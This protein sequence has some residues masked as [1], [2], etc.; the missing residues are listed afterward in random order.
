MEWLKVGCSRN[1]HKCWRLGNNAGQIHLVLLPP[2]HG[3]EKDL[4]DVYF[5]LIFSWN[6]SKCVWLDMDA[7]K[8]KDSLSFIPTFKERHQ[9][10][11]EAHVSGSPGA[12]LCGLWA[13]SSQGTCFLLFSFCGVSAKTGVNEGHT[14]SGF[15]EGKPPGSN[16]LLSIFP[17]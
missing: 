6:I 13:L 7:M 8:L 11:A 1:A 9:P 12:L 3:D 10:T 17:F 14:N 4:A 15:S 16:R 2:G 5:V